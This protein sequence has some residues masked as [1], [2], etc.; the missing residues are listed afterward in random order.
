MVLPDA[1]GPAGV[2]CPIG[3][4]SALAAWVAA[5]G[6]YDFACAVLRVDQYHCLGRQGFRRLGP[7]GRE[8]APDGI[9]RVGS[10][11]G[12]KRAPEKIDA[13]AGVTRRVTRIPAELR[14]AEVPRSAPPG[15]KGPVV[16]LGIKGPGSIWSARAAAVARCD[17]G[18]DH[19]PGDRLAVPQ[20]PR[21]RRGPGEH[22]EPAASDIPAAGAD[23]DRAHRGTAAAGPRGVR[24]RPRQPG[25]VARS[26]AAARRSRSRPQ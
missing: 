20:L 15:R 19:A 25:A 17:L 12:R 24:S 23:V 26:R 21:P 10:G 11:C 1:N 4:M 2:M 3:G 22:A 18:D 14:G 5:S 6:P 8:I 9:C 16:I 13:P 7:P